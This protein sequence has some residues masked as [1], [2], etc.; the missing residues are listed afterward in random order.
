MEKFN[1]TLS[2]DLFKNLRSDVLNGQ[3]VL[4]IVY[5]EETKKALI[6]VAVGRGCSYVIY[7]SFCESPNTK[8]KEL[9]GIDLNAK[10]QINEFYM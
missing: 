6:S 5:N 2:T 7:D 10:I 9:L 4:D 8:G 3:A 1:S